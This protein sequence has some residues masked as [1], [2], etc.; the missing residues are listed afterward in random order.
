MV[1]RRSTPG[2]RRGKEVADATSRGGSRHSTRA[3]RDGHGGDM[4]T[5]RSTADPLLQPYTL[6]HLTLRNRL[7]SSAHE[8]AYTDEGMPKQRYRV[9]HAEK[10]KGGIGLTMIGGSSVVAPDSPQAF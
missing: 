7:M 9:Y 3:G 8:P 10:A 4:S 1:R 6:R 5:A 2:G